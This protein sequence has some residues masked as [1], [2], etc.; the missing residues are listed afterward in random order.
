M[1]L[2]TVAT[3]MTQEPIEMPVFLFACI[4]IAAIIAIISSA[5][6]IWVLGF[7]SA[8]VRA[9]LA[10]ALQGYRKQNLPDLLH[11]IGKLSVRCP[12]AGLLTFI[13]KGNDPS[14]TAFPAATK[15][16]SIPFDLILF[17]T[18]QATALIRN[19]IVMLVL[20]FLWNFTRTIEA[21]LT[22]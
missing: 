17:R 20:A 16:A 5:K 22:G 13:Q 11:A 19:T 1:V 18:R 3:Q 15:A 12:E 2:I 8:G 14:I 10:Q 9:L 6:I 21:T 4:A 7:T